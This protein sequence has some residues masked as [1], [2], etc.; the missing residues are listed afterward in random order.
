MIPTLRVDSTNVRWVYTMCRMGSGY[1]RLDTHLSLIRDS[2]RRVDTSSILLCWIANMAVVSSSLHYIK[3]T[4]GEDTKSKM[5]KV[6]AESFAQWYLLPK[7]RPNCVDDVVAQ[8]SEHSASKQPAK[9]RPRR[10]YSIRTSTSVVSSIGDPLGYG[11]RQH[12]WIKLQ[13][14]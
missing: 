4:E 6:H 5:W 11:P 10:A 1:T 7:D 9:V 14:G 12:G 13:I 8:E 3:G 2:F